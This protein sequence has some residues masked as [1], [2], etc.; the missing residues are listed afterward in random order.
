MAL[1]VFCG[2]SFANLSSSSIYCVVIEI[3][4]YIY[5]LA[6]CEL[7]MEVILHRLFLMDHYVYFR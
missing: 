3:L 2:D 7:L 4:S 6:E 1:L 5:Y